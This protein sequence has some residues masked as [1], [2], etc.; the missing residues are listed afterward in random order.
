MKSVKIVQEE[1]GF[2]IYNQ[3]NVLLGKKYISPEKTEVV[4]LLKAI[5]FAEGA[6]DSIPAARNAGLFL[7]LQ[8]IFNFFLRAKNFKTKSAS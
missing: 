6:L 2:N 8:L 4:V 1:S 5:A 3:D 7:F